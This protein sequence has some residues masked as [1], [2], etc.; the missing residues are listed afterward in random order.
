MTHLGPNI[1]LWADIFTPKGVLG[2]VMKMI[3]RVFNWSPNDWAPL[4]AVPSIFTDFG[5]IFVPQGPIF[6]DLGWIFHDF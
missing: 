3:Q 6:T 4:L 1:A 2:A 5:H